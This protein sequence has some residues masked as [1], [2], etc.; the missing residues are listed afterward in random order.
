[1]TEHHDASDQID[2]EGADDPAFQAV[3]EGGGGVSEG[4]ELAEEDLIEGAEHGEHV[5]RDGFATEE[6]DPGSEF[7][8]ADSEA[9]EEDRPPQ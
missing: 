7:A 6:E 1:M 9:D 5:H 3:R 8:D 2:P 4:F